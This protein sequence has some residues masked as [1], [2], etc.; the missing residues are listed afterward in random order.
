MKL[1][2]PLVRKLIDRFEVLIAEG[3]EILRT[4]KSIPAQYKENWVTQRTVQA[5]AAYQELD[6]P[7]FVE[8]RTKAAT[9]LDHILPKDH[10]HYPV[11]K[12]LP[13]LASSDD[14]LA[15]AVSVLKGIKNDLEEGFL[16]S[17]FH[18]VE[19]EIAS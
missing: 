4:A 8:W 7:R 1:P 18:R 11:V 3:E 17:L 10:I 19:A 14:K 12:S 5:R 6:W 9:L 2:P 15:A 13:N 16:D